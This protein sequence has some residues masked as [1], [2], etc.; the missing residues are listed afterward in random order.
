MFFIN[1]MLDNRALVGYYTGATNFAK[2]PYY[3]LTAIYLVALPVITQRYSAKDFS[4]CNQ[5]INQFFE[6]IFLFILPIS[7]I[8]APFSGNLMAGFYRPEYRLAALPTAMLMFSQFFIG[9]MVV[10]NIFLYATS[11]KRYGTIVVTCV[12][13]LD[14]LLCFT[15][16]PRFSITGAAA[17]TL[18]SGLLGCVMTMIKVRKAFPGI[19]N[20]QLTVLVFSNLIYASVLMFLSKYLI[21]DNLISSIMLC[22]FA[23]IVFILVVWGSRIASPLNLIRNLRNQDTK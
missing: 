2:I 16:I 5:V 20:N 17:A 18:V 13:A 19:W 4:G 9:F 1:A 22:A 14:A 10:L 23:Y 11:A 6:T 12:L 15:L 21:I 7:C 3:L 8:A